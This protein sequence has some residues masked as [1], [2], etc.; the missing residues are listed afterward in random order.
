M[1]FIT[2]ATGM[3]GSRLVSHLRDKHAI[4][5]LVRK[6][7]QMLQ[8]LGIDQVQGNL[9]DARTYKHMLKPADQIIHLAAI[10][11][12]KDKDMWEV[13][14]EGTRELI[15][16]CDGQRFVY[17]STAG[18]YGDCNDGP[19]DETTAVDPITHYEKSK[20]ESEKYVVQLD[21]PTILRSTLAYG[22]SSY[23]RTIIKL[24]SKNFPLIGNGKN[25]FHL[26]YVEDLPDIIINALSE[27]HSGEVYN[28]AGKETLTLLET[29]KII[30]K[31]MG[32]EGRTKH[33][34]RGLV[35]A[36]SYL[37]QRIP[38]SLFAPSYV[39]R[40]TKNRIYNVEKAEKSGLGAK[41]RFKEGITEVIR[42][43]GLIQ[44]KEEE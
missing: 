23:W 38:K 19:V 35:L 11:D 37:T 7:D 26:V 39:K 40:L 1:I 12:E 17:I 18:V 28:I 41:T 9:L 34:P 20:L 42:D 3:I 27:R 22:P 32:V 30:K 4:T 10:I 29:Y 24:I 21:S 36:L 6:P 14:V 8:S 33:L 31:I 43:L 13:N 15:S 5:A 25:Y 16:A 44:L 2:G